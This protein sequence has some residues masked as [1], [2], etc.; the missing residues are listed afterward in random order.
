VFA[1]DRILDFLA[2]RSTIIL[3][4][5]IIASILERTRFQEVVEITE[6]FLVVKEKWGKKLATGI[7]DKMIA[8]MERKGHRVDPRTR[9]AMIDAWATVVTKGL[10]SP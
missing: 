10:L 1:L 5:P 4:K 2:R 9:E 7:V 3:R 6:P 8:E